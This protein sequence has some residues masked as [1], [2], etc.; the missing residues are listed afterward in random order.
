MERDMMGKRVT[1][2]KRFYR[3]YRGDWRKWEV[4]DQEPAQGWLVGFRTIWDGYL[5]SDT[6]E[7]GEKVGDD[8]FVHD[9]HHNCVLV[10]FSPRQNPVNVPMDGF[11]LAG[12]SDG[13]Q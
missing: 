4:T 9:T 11:V 2:T 3:F 7:Y 8:Y 12:G 10:S 13:N 5:D 1:V 6:G